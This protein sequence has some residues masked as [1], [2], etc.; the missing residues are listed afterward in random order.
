[1][2]LKYVHNNSNFIVLCKFVLIISQVYTALRNVIKVLNNNFLL[3]SLRGNRTHYTPTI[4][5]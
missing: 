2:S 3:I 5:K 1:M 4:F